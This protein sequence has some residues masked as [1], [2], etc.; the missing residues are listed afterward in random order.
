MSA[1]ADALVT[2][3]NQKYSSLKFNLVIKLDIPASV[4]K[5]AMKRIITGIMGK[6]HRISVGGYKQTTRF[7]IS[8]AVGNT[9]SYCLKKQYPIL[10]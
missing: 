5:K 3:S 2:A 4:R 1:W 10:S 6:S 7:T 9:I 8:R